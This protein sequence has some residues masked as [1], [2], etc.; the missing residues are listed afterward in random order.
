[1]YRAGFD[2]AWEPDVFGGQRRAVEAAQA[3]L[4]RSAAG[5]DDT[6]VSL[7]AE[8]AL[9]YVEVRAFQARLAIAQG[10]LATQLETAQLTDWRAQ[11]G[12]VSALEADQARAAAEQT[13]AGIP[14]FEVGIAQAEHRL[15]LLL[16]QTP[17]TLQARLA[18]PG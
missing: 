12:L 11:A 18:A 3:D 14:T 7:A 13:R 10:N 1:L 2:A 5:L 6:R 4:E 16:G 17:G 9:S 15:A 8:V